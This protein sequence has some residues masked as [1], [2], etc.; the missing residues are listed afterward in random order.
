MTSTTL[1]IAEIKNKITVISNKFRPSKREGYSAWTHSTLIKSIPV[2]VISV[3]TLEIEDDTSWFS[4][5][6]WQAM[7]RE[8]DEDFANGRFNRVNS[9][10]ELLALLDG[11]KKR[12]NK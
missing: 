5:P 8:I 9:V 11:Q 2:N 10:E 4:D 1:E 6:E 3:S 12:S 7:E